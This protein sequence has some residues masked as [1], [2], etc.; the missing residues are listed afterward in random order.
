MFAMFTSALLG[1]LASLCMAFCLS[2]TAAAQPPLRV[3]LVL[4]YEGSDAW[5]DMLRN[6]LEE[7]RVRY[8]L[9]TRVLRAAGAEQASVFRSIAAEGGL[10]LLAS[11]GLHEVLRDN[12]G[13]YR[14]TMFGCIDTGVRAPNIMSVSFADE[15]PAFLAGA[16]AA[17]LTR[18]TALPGINDQPVLGWLSGEDTHALRSMLKA[19]HE[20]AQLEEPGIRVIH[21]VAGSWSD[22]ERARAQALRLMD[23]GAD[24]L[25]LAAGAA[26]AGAL[27]AV[28][29]RGGYIIGMDA[30]ASATLPGRVLASIS[31]RADEA[32]LTIV[33]AAAT[34]RFKGKKIIT[35][36]MADGGTNLVG[37]K[38]FLRA[39]GNKTPQHME[40]RLNELRQELIKGN[41]RLKSLRARTLCDCL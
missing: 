40:S 26:N 11:D 28:Q 6:G 9:E 21:A 27:E 14:K 22:T 41:I 34:G 25:V 19:F 37:L 18:T 38:T 36:N 35:R 20:G 32:V 23:A 12:A 13:N 8:G 3:S 7:A 5:S 10:V 15:E 24:V 4:E 17:I 31:K 33:G 16:A 29:E 39:A 2:T 1:C 30:D